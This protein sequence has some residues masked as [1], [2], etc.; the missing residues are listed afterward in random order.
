MTLGG[1][2]GNR[3]P[4]PRDLNLAGYAGAHAAVS[5][6]N[7]EWQSAAID[8]GRHELEFLKQKTKSDARKMVANM[9]AERL[10]LCGMSAGAAG[11]P[12]RLTST[13]ARGGNGAA[14]YGTA[15]PMGLA[16]G[17]RTPAAYVEQPPP[18]EAAMGLIAATGASTFYRKPAV[19]AI[20][21]AAVSQAMQQSQQSQQSQMSS[22]QQQQPKPE[23][24]HAGKAPPPKPPSPSMGVGSS[25]YK[26]PR[27]WHTRE[28]LVACVEET[29]RR[30]E[31]VESERDGAR[32]ACEMLK[33]EVSRAEAKEH[34]ALAAASAAKAYS[35]TVGENEVRLRMMLEEQGAQLATASRE[36]ASVREAL[37]EAQSK[38][39][40]ANERLDAVDAQAAAATKRAEKADRAAREAREALAE[41]R[42]TQAEVD[43]LRAAL[44]EA[45]QQVANLKAQVAEEANARRSLGIA[46]KESKQALAKLREEAD[47]QKAQSDAV[48]A[49]ELALQRE[50][51]GALRHVNGA[52][53]GRLR[54]LFNMRTD[55]KSK[56][57]TLQEA[58]QMLTDEYVVVVD[59]LR[60]T[61]EALAQEQR[62]SGALEGMLAAARDEARALMQQTR[63]AEANLASMLVEVAQHDA[64]LVPLLSR[65]AVELAQV[66]TNLSEKQRRDAQDSATTSRRVQQAESIAARAAESSAALESE[67]ALL[68]KRLANSLKR[69]RE[70]QEQLDAT[71]GPGGRHWVPPAAGAGGQRGTPNASTTKSPFLGGA[72]GGGSTA[73]GGMPPRAPGAAGGKPRAQ[74]ADEELAA[75][76]AEGG[77][78]RPLE[79]EHVRIERDYRYVREEEQPS[80]LT[81]TPVAF[82]VN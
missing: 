72:A 82:T 71:G 61:Q 67:V 29:T 50:R 52:L 8:S 13:P 42:A 47:A 44:A 3:P 14:A 30:A 59:Q 27:A 76:E 55:E 35:L 80:P 81:V 48:M 45:R 15:S 54:A 62:H 56:A 36:E 21:S 75:L 70:L 57:T 65:Q 74:T 6:P 12:M 32:M 23:W 2:K 46:A 49:R 5:A 34:E 60:S 25:P 58:V 19:N 38:L 26:G 51:L 24:R 68:K 53:E 4:P 78:A 31:L 1:A 69:T 63:E 64:L 39:L 66:R 9:V 73:R 77:Y 43:A 37:R 22:Q 20:V 10:A 28:E 16:D 41:A 11:E 17:L 7:A 18:P 79:R 33:E 40:Q